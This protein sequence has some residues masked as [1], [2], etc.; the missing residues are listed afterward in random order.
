[1]AESSGAGLLKQKLIWVG[2]MKLP[3]RKV[4]SKH[5]GT[6]QCSWNQEL[7]TCTRSMAFIS[8]WMFPAKVSWGRKRWNASSMGLTFQATG[9]LQVTYELSVGSDL[10]SPSSLGTWA[11]PLWWGC[12][13]GQA[14][15]QAG[16]ISSCPICPSWELWELFRHTKIEKW[17]R[18]WIGWS[19]QFRWPG[20]LPQSYD[21]VNLVPQ[22][23]RCR[24]KFRVINDSLNLGVCCH[25]RKLLC[26]LPL[27]SEAEWSA[28]ENKKSDM[29]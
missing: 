22:K 15:Q 4:G 2:K 19:F 11:L 28:G 21:S 5:N 7:C 14:A 23:W 26:L 27:S 25:G 16:P 10:L 29:S 3:T 1:M 20:L 12:T 8:A 6:Q 17:G 18:I 13:W 9:V 24:E